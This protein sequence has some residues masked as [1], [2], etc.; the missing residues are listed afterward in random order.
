MGIKWEGV[1]TGGARVA[2]FFGLSILTVWTGVQ[3]VVVKGDC[4]YFVVSTAG[5][6]VLKYFIWCVCVDVDVSRRWS[7]ELES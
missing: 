5:A 1:S 6:G 4:V 3:S 2:M 7:P